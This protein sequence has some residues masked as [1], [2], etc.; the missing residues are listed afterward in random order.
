[1]FELA[2]DCSLSNAIDPPCGEAE[3]VATCDADLPLISLREPTPVSCFCW[4]VWGLIGVSSPLR[5]DVVLLLESKLS[6][7]IE[8]HSE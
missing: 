6:R 2:A 4:F 1:M 7:E 3:I 8:R 5:L